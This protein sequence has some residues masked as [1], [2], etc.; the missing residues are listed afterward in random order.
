MD[1]EKQRP[2]H[3]WQ[4]GVSGNAKG[5][6]KG[7]SQVNELRKE[8]M[9]FA[10]EIIATLLDQ[11]K[12]GDVQAAKLLLERC[13]PVLKP[14]AAPAP[15]AALES[16][17]DIHSLLVGIV[18]AIAFG[19]LSVADGA[20]LLSAIGRLKGGPPA[21]PQMSLEEIDTKIQDYI[22]QWPVAE[23]KGEVIA[24]LS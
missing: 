8:I 19:E 6:P 24:P 5:R 14:E 3:L 10:P 9:K 12:G 7:V 13:V 1:I 4:P 18:K 21:A 23:N 11:A 22:N 16:A 17:T 20:S 15:I 2:T